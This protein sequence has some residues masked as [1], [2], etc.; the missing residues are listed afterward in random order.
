[1]RIVTGVGDLVQMTGDGR[2]DQ[3][4]GGRTIRRS[5]DTMCS[6]HHARGDKERGFL[7]STSKS[8]STVY[9]WFDLKI[10][11]MVFSGLIS[12]LV[13]TIFSDLAS[14]MVATVFTGLGSKPMTTVSPGLPSK[15]VVTFLVEPQNQAGFGFFSLD[16]NTDTYSLMIYAS[17]SP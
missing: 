8:R 10:T 13:A 5:G 12:K 15:S 11:G 4:L 2:T 1:M 7:G 6:L 17:K 16:L 9:Q 14:K 3:V